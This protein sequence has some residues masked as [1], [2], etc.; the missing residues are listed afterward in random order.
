MDLLSIVPVNSITEILTFNGLFEDSINKFKVRRAMAIR[1]DE[2]IFSHAA[3]DVEMEVNLSHDQHQGSMWHGH[4][5]SNHPALQLHMEIQPNLMKFQLQK[6][7]LPSG[8]IK[9]GWKIT[10]QWRF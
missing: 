9:H 4:I 3:A 10:Y 6:K 7:D 2:R 8:V 5:P 1:E